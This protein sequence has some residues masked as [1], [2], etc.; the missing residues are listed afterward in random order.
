M[1][2]YSMGL[3][4]YS[5]LALKPPYDGDEEII[6]HVLDGIRPP[7][8]PSWHPGFI[9]VSSK[10]CASHFPRTA[11]PCT[12]VLFLAQFVDF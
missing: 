7:I 12:C 2:I 6:S 11:E 10:C 1:D 4:F 9:A 8:D 3:V 5:M